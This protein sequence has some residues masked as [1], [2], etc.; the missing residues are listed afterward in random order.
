MTGVIRVLAGLAIAAAGVG[1]GAG[2]AF[3]AVCDIERVSVSES[4]LEGDG[5]SARFGGDVAISGAGRYVLFGSE[6]T[7]LVP[8]GTN[9]SRNLFLADTS[10]NSLELISV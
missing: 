3:A 7:N 4:G 2:P 10:T 8:G 9:G 5:P 1:V 6:A